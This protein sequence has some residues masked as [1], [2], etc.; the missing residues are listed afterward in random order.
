M[1]VCLLVARAS[2]TL[3]L[4]SHS[5]DRNRSR[6]S[7]TRRH[8]N[9]STHR[10]RLDDNIVRKQY[11]DSNHE[12][13]KIATKGHDKKTQTCDVD[14]NHD[15]ESCL[16]CGDSCVA[17][18]MFCPQDNSPTVYGTGAQVMTFADVS[19]AIVNEIDRLLQLG[20]DS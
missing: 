20:E 14:H 4:L 18:E 7:N 2:P 6:D 13:D 10:Q 17:L 12:H 1:N 5:L 16:V 9:K 8:V 19:N 15:V 11:D 3:H